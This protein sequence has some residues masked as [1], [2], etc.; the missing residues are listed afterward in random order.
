[1][2]CRLSPYFLIGRGGGI[3]AKSTSFQPLQFAILKFELKKSFCKCFFTQYHE[4]LWQ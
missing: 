2:C 4:N 1:M 3:I